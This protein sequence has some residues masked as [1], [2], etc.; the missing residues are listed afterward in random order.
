M[1]KKQLLRRLDETHQQSLYLLRDVDPE[2][3]VYGE[4]GWR[5]KDIVAHVATWDAET[6]RSFHA[7]RRG[8]EY[9]IPNYVGVD[10]FN[11]YAASMR[12][13]EPF[14]QIMEDWEA[15]RRWLDIILNV[16][17]EADFSAEMTYP[18][19]TRGTAGQLVQEISEHE[20]EHMQHIRAAAEVR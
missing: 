11:G 13:D 10:D 14:A 19:G 16:M 20:A 6:L 18:S 3:L 12:M 9:T 15:T 2:Q 7:F 1:E 4:S 17:R 5:V 8:G